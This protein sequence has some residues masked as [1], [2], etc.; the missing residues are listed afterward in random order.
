MPL[1]CLIAWST[2][3]HS[4]HHV[5][6]LWMVLINSLTLGTLLFN[7]QPSRAKSYFTI[8]ARRDELDGLNEAGGAAA[9]AGGGFGR[10]APPPSERYGAV[11]D[12]GF[13]GAERYGAGEPRRSA[14]PDEG[15]L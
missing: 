12:D 14:V 15:M 5:A 1:V 13:I 7:F 9:A 4:R 11:Q 10:S 8:S 6:T 2:D 3:R